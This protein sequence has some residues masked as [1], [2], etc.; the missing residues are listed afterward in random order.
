MRT[1]GGNPFPRQYDRPSYIVELLDYFGRPYEIDTQTVDKLWGEIISRCE[2]RGNASTIN[3]WGAH[4]IFYTH[5]LTKQVGKSSQVVRRGLREIVTA[6]EVDRDKSCE[7]LAKTLATFANEAAWAIMFRITS[8]GPQ[9]F[10]MLDQF[11][12]NYE[13]TVTT[14]NA[15]PITT[16]S[17]TSR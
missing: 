3:K 2:I 16:G 7:A 8:C 11:W 17:F 13:G 14:G 1:D 9:T 4:E 5:S 15:F 10:E 12:S 6:A